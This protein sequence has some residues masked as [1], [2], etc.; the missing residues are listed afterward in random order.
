MLRLKQLMTFSY[1]LSS[2]PVGLHVLEQL[3]SQ[4]IDVAWSKCA[5]LPS[6]PVTCGLVRALAHSISPTRVLRLP[7]LLDVVWLIF[8]SILVDLRQKIELRS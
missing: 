1:R 3:V 6:K 8:S 2:C 7:Q 4:G 5:N